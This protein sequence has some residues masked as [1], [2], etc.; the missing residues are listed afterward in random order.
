MVFFIFYIYKK[1]KFGILSNLN[2]IDLIIIK[3]WQTNV[4]NA[5]TQQI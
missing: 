2:Y 3:S 1:I 5:G 4:D